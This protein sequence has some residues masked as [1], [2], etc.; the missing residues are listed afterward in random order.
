MIKGRRE[1]KAWVTF[2]KNPCKSGV[3]E[4]HNE[5]TDT[6]L[7]HGPLDI[8]NPPFFYS[9]EHSPHAT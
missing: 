4:N 9:A 5:N 2:V 1:Q 7:L 3:S 6:P 8:T